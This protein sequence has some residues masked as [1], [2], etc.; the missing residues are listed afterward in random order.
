MGVTL[1]RSR[2]TSSHCCRFGVEY[3]LLVLRKRLSSQ[4]QVFPPPTKL[5]E[6]SMEKGMLMVR[7]GEK[8]RQEVYPLKAVAGSSLCLSLEGK[9]AVLNV[10]S[11]SWNHSVLQHAL[12]AQRCAPIYPCYNLEKWFLGFLQ[13]HSPV[14]ILL[15]QYAEYEERRP[16]AA[17]RG[18]GKTSIPS[19][20]A[21]KSTAA[22][23][24]HHLSSM[25]IQSIGALS[26]L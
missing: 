13:K 23:N 5:R 14:Y 3:I 17:W 22:D 11:C 7:Q 12:K 24:L 6:Q 4:S 9:W 21:E 1:H 18:G 8:T 16:A 15:T 25:P 26:S 19:A 20:I 2:I 10:F